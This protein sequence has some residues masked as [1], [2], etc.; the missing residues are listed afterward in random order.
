VKRPFE[1][2]AGSALVFGCALLVACTANNG[3]SSRTGNGGSGGNAGATASGTAGASGGGSGS[4]ST[5]GG[6]STAGAGG[7]AG[8][9]GAAGTTSVGAAGATGGSGGSAGGAAT[10]AGQSGAGGQTTGADS[11]VGGAGFPSITECT[12]ASV[13]RLEDWTSSG[14]AEGTT[15][16]PTGNLLVK[17]GDH[18]IAKV[19]FLNVEWH[20][21]PV[22]L[23]NQFNGNANLSAS[24]GFQLTYSATADFYVQ[25]RPTSHWSGGTQWATKI[26]STG[27]V[28]KTQFFSFQPA[29]WKSIFD[30]PTWSLADTLKEVLGFVFVGQDPNTI[31]FYGLRFDGYV[32]PCQ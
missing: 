30:A 2:R 8:D 7:A 18:Y 5:G 24:S 23:A 28:K 13:D 14:P 27:G 16:P 1:L 29:S 15:I 12:K 32:P 31:T 22:Y 10:D 4:S 21:C 19:Q 11:G 6:A 26:P 20:V 3:G 25:A 17:E 9:S